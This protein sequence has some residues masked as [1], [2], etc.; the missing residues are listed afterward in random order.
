MVTANDLRREDEENSKMEYKV[1][2]NAS[3]ARGLLS[4]SES[5]FCQEITCLSTSKDD[6]RMEMFKYNKM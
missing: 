5:D 6:S 3:H 1:V 2:K 4:S